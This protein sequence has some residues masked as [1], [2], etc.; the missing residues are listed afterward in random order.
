MS[1]SLF[2]LTGAATPA[3]LDPPFTRAIRG[4]APTAGTGVPGGV[5]NW[6]LTISTCLR[7]IVDAA[8]EGL[9]GC[10]VVPGLVWACGPARS[11][12]GDDSEHMMMSE[13][14]RLQVQL[15]SYVT[16]GAEGVL[17]LPWPPGQRERD[18]ESEAEELAELT[19]GCGLCPSQVVIDLPKGAIAW[20][21][22][23]RLWLEALI[24]Q[25]HR[26]G[27]K[28]AIGGLF[29]GVGP[30]E[31]VSQLWPDIASVESEAIVRAE[32]DPVWRRHLGRV[33]KLIRE[34]YGLRF[35]ARAVANRAQAEIACECAIDWL[36]GPYLDRS[37]AA[38][39]HA[40]PASAVAA[41]LA[42]AV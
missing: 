30:L 17:L 19:R 29:R 38:P 12:F 7:P 15:F 22:P 8:S 10:Q 1:D 26:A 32:A 6:A 11:S 34:L 3:R 23:A 31:S 41:R 24:R 18:P 14:L 21:G 42:W 5:G 36:E 13:R 20:R 4:N 39:Q 27:F 40:V 33:L 2:A 28:V 35:L 25:Y 16:W 9:R 37:A